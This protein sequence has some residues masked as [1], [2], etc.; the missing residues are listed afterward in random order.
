MENNSIIEQKKVLR[1]KFRS[2][3]ENMTTDERDKASAL[4]VSRLI[5]NPI[6][7]SAMTIMAYASMPEEIQLN[8]LFDDAF[9]HNKI[10]AV[11]LIIGRGTMRPVF[12]PSMDDLVVGD[13]GILTVRQDCRTFVEFNDIDCIIVPGAAFDRKGNRLGLGGGY[14]DRFLKRAEHASRIALA[15]DY[16]IVD[17]LPVCE[18]DTKMDVI[19][20]ESEILTFKR[21]E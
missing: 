5:D 20:T 4:I 1:K 14:Y 10:L 6:Y 17:D 11:P 15:F 16:Q 8:K 18:Y 19:I 2:M 7:K 12:L 3:R 21:G 9:S 13:F